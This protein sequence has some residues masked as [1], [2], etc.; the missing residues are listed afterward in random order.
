MNPTAP[1]RLSRLLT[2]GLL[3]A[4]GVAAAGQITDRVYMKGS[5]KPQLVQ[6]TAESIDKGIKAGP[7]GFSL[8]AVA[9]VE[10][11]DAPFAFREAEQ[12]REQARYDEAIRLYQTALRD[13]VC[14]RRW[15]L[16]PN[17]KYKIALCHLE[18]G[19]PDEAIQ[20][21]QKLLAEHPDTRWKP[22]AFLGLGR[23]YFD[24]RQYAAAVQQFDRLARLA[25]EKEFEGWLLRAYLWKAKALRANDRPKEAMDL[26]NK[27]LGARGDKHEDVYI[28]ARTEEAVIYMAQQRYDKA[29]DLLNDL[30]QR[31]ANAVAKEIESGTETRYQRVEARCFNTLGRCY[32]EMGSKK[33]TAPKDKE[34]R[35]WEALL[36]FLWNVV[37][38]QR[39]PAEHAEALFYAAQCF[40][41]LD[42]RTRA[43]ELRN[44]L[45]QRYP[46][47]LYAQKVQPKK[48]GGN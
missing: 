9:R 40:D 6:I 30:I 25:A 38:Y 16:E 42:Q 29:V 44:E 37:L 24:Q 45:V 2:A 4:A 18:A 10:Y 34:S 19:E 17:C 35:Y 48:A 22:D 20:A 26:I 15:W 8:K 3:A 13:Q 39:L 41:K 7:V 46:D 33:A 23:V 14:K 12:H 47:T 36:S 28:E 1:R 31:I 27:I 32:L 43:T 11:G 21:F 5:D